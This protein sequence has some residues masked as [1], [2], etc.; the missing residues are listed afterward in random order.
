VNE[1]EIRTK[2]RIFKDGKQKETYSDKKA[3]EEQCGMA[4]EAALRPK[5]QNSNNL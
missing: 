2:E 3:S 5:I 4:S 1:K